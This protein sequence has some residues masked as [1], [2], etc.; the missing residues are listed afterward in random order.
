MVSQLSPG[1]RKVGFALES[2]GNE[3]TASVIPAARPSDEV[4]AP[5][6]AGRNG[7]PVR[8]RRARALKTSSRP[9]L[10]VAD[11]RQHHARELSASRVQLRPL[12]RQLQLARADL[13]AGKFS[14]H[15]ITPAIPPLLR[16]RVQTRVPC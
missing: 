6:H 16:R 8:L 9:P 1:P 7:I 5:A 10:R 2:A 13:D 15:R 11:E 12:R 4:S 14:P 3:T